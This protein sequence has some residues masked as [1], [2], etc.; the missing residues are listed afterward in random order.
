MFHRGP[1]LGAAPIRTD[2]GWLLLFSNESM[3]RQWTVGAALLD[4]NNPT[5][6]LGRTSGR[7][8]EPMLPWEVDGMVPV[9]TFPSGAVIN[10]GLV[11]LYYGAADACIGLAEVP[12]TDLLDHIFAQ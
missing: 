11:R 8:L 1:E 7:I 3:G 10:Q 6:L 5:K 2:E 9:V 12:L 4:L